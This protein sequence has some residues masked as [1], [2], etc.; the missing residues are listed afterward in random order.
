MENTEQMSLLEIAVKLIEEKGPKKINDLIKEALAL[1]G[2]DSNNTDAAVQ[3]YVDMTASSKFVYM[4]DDEWDLKANQPLE[5]FDRDGSSFISKE[6]EYIPEPDE[7]D[8]IFVDDVEEKS[9]EDEEDEDSDN[10]SK[11]MY[12]DDE[13]AEAEDEEDKKSDSGELEIDEDMERYS[14]ED[15]NEDEYGDEDFNEDEYNDL[16]D[17]YED[18]YDD[19]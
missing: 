17:D 7:E 14:E 18:M 10:D 1:K 5:A 13:D 3:L 6:E 15:Y 4:G 9:D 2:I 19:K 11:S 8:D 12:I 16:M